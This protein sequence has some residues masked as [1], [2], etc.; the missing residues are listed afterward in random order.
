MQ[1][2]RSRVW[3]A[4]AA[5]AGCA[6]LLAGCA[7]GAPAPEKSATTTLKKID[8][9]TFKGKSITYVYFSDGA[10][11]QAA[12]QE[13]VDKF[14]K[15]TGAKVELQIVPFANIETALQARLSGGDVPDVARVTSLM[16]P[17]FSDSLINMTQYFGPSFEKEFVP[18]AAQTVLDSAGNMLGA[19]SDL[20]MNG[21]LINVTQFKKAG[22]AIP[23]VDKPW[24][25]DQMIADAK[26]V[27]KAN[28]TDFAYVLDKSG[29]R[30]STV[31]SEFGTTMISAKGTNGLDKTKAIKAVGA[32]TD[33]MK[34]NEMS[35]DFWLATGSKYAGG[36]DMFLAGAVPVYLSGNWQVS[37]FAK[38][39][40]FEWAAV[41]N[42]CEQRCGGFPGVK[43]TVAF[44]RSKNPA[45]AAYFVKWLSEKAQ[46]TALDKAA[47]WMP[48]RADLV[49]SGIKYPVRA[50]DMNVF[51]SDVSKT[52]ASTYAS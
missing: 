47:N 24:T 41:P 32:L 2:S 36:N 39:A 43:D 5:L 25:W 46:Q 14:Q 50:A 12:T 8:V 38:S 31:L 48:T 23:T 6:M 37:A 9:K 44:N 51:L 29:H 13:Q 34:S 33:L 3:L 42:P 26:K 7:P 20:T 16:V 27:Q 17:S 30:V 11:D 4:A 15:L 19:P 10:A 52:P 35:K 28:N 22:V 1:N 40:T 21:P 45:L 49:A 18:G